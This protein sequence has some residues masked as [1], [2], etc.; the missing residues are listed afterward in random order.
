MWQVRIQA[1]AAAADGIRQASDRWD[2]VSDSLCDEDG[3]PID[4]ENYAD[5]NVARDAAAWEHVETFLAHGP[6][7]L[8]GVRAA[9]TGADYADGPISSDLRRLHGIDT[10]L[11]RA[12][13]IRREWQEAI[14]LVT[15]STHG[16]RD[17]YEVQTR[18][19]RN[20]EGWHHADELAGSGK[21]LVR[22]AEPLTGRLGIPP[23]APERRIQAALQRS[24]MGLRSASAA[25]PAAPGTSIPGAARRSR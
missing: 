18:E 10:D 8:A 2:A 16:S 11:T 20:A 3:W 17:I 24:A 13:E 19:L 6:A 4:E 5:G 22:A 7:V 25:D 15:S 12:A 23:G 14:A 1:L 21:A 9:A